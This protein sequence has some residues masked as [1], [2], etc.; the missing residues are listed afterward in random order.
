MSYD[1]N[2]YLKLL[3]ENKFEEAN[4]YKLQNMLK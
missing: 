3:I 1:K 4:S 2:R